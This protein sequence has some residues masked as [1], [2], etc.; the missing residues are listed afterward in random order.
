MYPPE[1][2]TLPGLVQEHSALELCQVHSSHHVHPR[3]PQEKDAGRSHVSCSEAC[4][5]CTHQKFEGF[6]W[7]DSGYKKRCYVHKLSSNLSSKEREGS[8]V[9][10]IS[11]FPTHMAPLL[12]FRVLSAISS[13]VWGE[14][15]K[16]VTLAN[17]GGGGGPRLSTQIQV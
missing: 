4:L 17:A 3:P 14:A 12:K 16:L 8:L 6:F 11:W 7:G 13:G 9:T 5:N 10:T 1:K 15:G 2:E